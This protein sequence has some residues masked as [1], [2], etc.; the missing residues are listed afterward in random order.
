MDIFEKKI[1][2]I[3]ISEREKNKKE[4]K[5]NGIPKY[6]YDKIIKLIDRTA[7]DKE[8]IA[9]MESMLKSDDELLL[10]ILMKDPKRQNIYENILKEEVSKM[11]IEIEKLKS[12]GKNAFYPIGDEIKTNNAKK[13]KELKSLDFKMKTKSGE[14]I[15]IVHKYTNENGGAQ[16]NQYYD[17]INQLKQLGEKTIK[18]VWFCLDGRYYNEKR[19]SDLKNIN[20][21]IVIVNIDSIKSYWEKN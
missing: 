17:V 21:E 11:G 13:P 6:Y 7:L 5:E 1:K 9:T 10:T 14:T 4:I 16:D 2:E 12:W 3:W 19:I 8:V 18:K 20:S 15:Y